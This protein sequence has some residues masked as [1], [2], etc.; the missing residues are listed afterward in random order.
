[1]KKNILLLL[2]LGL[3]ACTTQAQE[4]EETESSFVKEGAEMPHFTFKDIEGKERSSDEFKGKVILINFFATWC[5]PC[6]VE[7]SLLQKQIWKKYKDNPNFIIASF[8]RDHSQEEIKEFIH[9]KNLSFNVFPDK[10]RLVYNLF[11]SKFIPR[12]YLIDKD[13]KTVLLSTGFSEEE[14]QLLKDKIQSLLQ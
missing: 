9:K 5:Q 13:G 11:A 10:G 8:G 12:N 4:D 14:F 3:F 6:L 1:M 2:I 7:M